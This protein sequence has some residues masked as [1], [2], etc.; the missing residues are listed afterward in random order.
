MFWIWMILE[1][2][3]GVCINSVESFLKSNEE[4]SP[5]IAKKRDYFLMAVAMSAVLV[6][7][8]GYCR[9]QENPG[10]FSWG[11]LVL[12]KLVNHGMM[13]TGLYEMIYTVIVGVPYMI[14]KYAP[15]TNA[16]TEVAIES[17]KDAA[18]S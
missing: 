5:E 11:E 10:L 12:S 1:V 9:V 17:D 6:F 15:R 8:I 14:K 3:W 4:V 7:M 13:F 18:L 16:N 2:V